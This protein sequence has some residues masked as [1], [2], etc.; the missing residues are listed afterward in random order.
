[1]E[2]YKDLSKIEKFKKQT[3]I[4]IYGTNTWAGK[5][6]DTIL[7]VVILASALIFFIDSV[8]SIHE[9]NGVLLNKL[10]WTFTILFTIEYILRIWV[11]RK[12]INYIF[13]FYGIVDLLAI[14]P[15]YLLF[16]L[17]FSKTLGVIRLLRLLRVLRI[18][19]LIN[20][21]S[22]AN[23]LRNALIQ[24]RRKILVFTGFVLILACVIG[25]L[26]YVIE[27]PEHGF[28]SIPNSIYWTIVTLTTVGYGD[29]TPHTDLG[30]F[31]SIIIMIIGYGVI[32]IPTGIVTGQMVMDGMLKA[33]KSEEE[34]FYSC[35][36][37]N[38]KSITKDA[39]Y[40]HKCGEEL[41]KD[42]TLE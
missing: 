7:L 10:E 42:V 17:P 32:A 29:I 4:I 28:T 1:M 39:K 34:D 14:L 22:E 31:I 37:C 33:K 2:H 11:T 35:D 13:S 15:S 25:T 20:F 40:C 6:F 19:K 26:M 18:L 16:F 27:G 21:I 23:V 41:H 8:P 9:K 5:L 12:P 24:S 36:M 38:T 30:K 3:Y